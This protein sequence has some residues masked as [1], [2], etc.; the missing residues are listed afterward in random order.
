[1]CRRRTDKTLINYGTSVCFCTRCGFKNTIVMRKKSNRRKFG[2]L[3]KLW[4][5]ICKEYVNHF[6]VNEYDLFERFD[7]N[8]FLEKVNNGFFDNVN[9]LPKLNNDVHLF[10]DFFNPDDGNKNIV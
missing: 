10:D 6:E 1:M 9:Q 5:P 8:K 7:Y 2:H 3:K 4:C